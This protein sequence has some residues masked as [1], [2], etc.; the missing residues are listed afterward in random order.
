MTQGA[1][2]VFL[3]GYCTH[4]ILVAHAD[5]F[6]NVRISVTGALGVRAYTWHFSASH[7]LPQRQVDPLQLWPPAHLK[8]EDPS[9]SSPVIPNKLKTILDG[10]LES[11][12]LIH[13]FEEGFSIPHTDLSLKWSSRNH[14][15]A[16]AQSSFLRQYVESELLEGRLLG[17]FSHIP[18][19]NFVC[20]PSV[21]SPQKTTRYLLCNSWPVIPQRVRCRWSHS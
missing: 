12:F 17:L 1:R 13:G 6:L 16:H 11:D 14:P 7:Q 19:P 18:H 3:W 15:S 10:H 2:Q 5:T 9:P 20:S 8:N 4:L 21:W